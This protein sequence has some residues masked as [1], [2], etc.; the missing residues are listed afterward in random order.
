M[1]K[2]LGT[3]ACG[4]FVLLL[5]ASVY[6]SAQTAVGCRCSCGKTLPPPC[7]DEA[8]EAACTSN[9]PSAPA[10]FERGPDVN[11]LR[12][13]AEAGDPQSQT[14]LGSMYAAG[15]KGLP[16]DDRQAV[17]W[18]RKAAEQEY[19]PAECL[20][21]QEYENGHGGL[22]KD[23]VEAVSWYRKAAERGEK[24]CQL[25]LGLMYEEGRG[26]LPRNDMQAML[27]FRKAA[28]QGVSRAQYHLG[29][30]YAEARGGLPKD[31]NQAVSWFRKAADEGYAPAQNSL[32]L[33]YKNGRGGLS[34]DDAQ[35][36][37]WYRRAAEQGFPVAQNNLAWLYATSSNPQIRN[38]ELAVQ[39]AQKAVAAENNADNFDTLAQAYYVRQEFQKAAQAEQQAVNLAPNDQKPEFQARLKK[40]E[41]AS[42]LGHAVE[43]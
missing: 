26:G 14:L 20:L 40:F 13:R 28:G 34:P 21:G 25:D 42:Q 11:A 6:S 37:Y 3:W 5:A 1:A 36:A 7:S 18:Y 29:A 35:A 38:P 31:D 17:S 24:T 19:A 9:F 12:E 43:P 8:C 27:W 2:K 32:G 16:Q 22:P 23:D 33:M 30:M 4:G 39:F 10:P 15:G 41:R